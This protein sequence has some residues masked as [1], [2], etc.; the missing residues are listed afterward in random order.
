MLNLP[1]LLYF[2]GNATE[3]IG[4]KEDIAKAIKQELYNDIFQNSE[5]TI[6]DK[7]SKAELSTQSEYITH[8]AYQRAYKKLKNKIEMGN[9][10]LSS[11][12]K[13]LTHRIAETELSRRT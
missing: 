3:N 12:K 6:A 8:I 13:V 10:V 7:T 5:G 9:E 4:V 11:V 1:L 2:T